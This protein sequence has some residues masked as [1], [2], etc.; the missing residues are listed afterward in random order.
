VKDKRTVLLPEEVHQRAQELADAANQLEPGMRYSKAGMISGALMK[1][2]DSQRTR[3]ALTYMQ[4]EELKRAARLG[5]AANG[6]QGFQPG[7]AR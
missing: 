5:R 6:A 1:L 3:G 4:R 2:A 7:G